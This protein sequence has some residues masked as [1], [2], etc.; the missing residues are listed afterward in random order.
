MDIR[1]RLALAL[2]SSG[3]S[4]DEGDD[5]LVPIT[6]KLTLLH[7]TG[8]YSRLLS[9]LFGA[10]DKANIQS[11]ILEASFAFQFE[12][13]GRPL[14]YEVRRRSDSDT[15]ID[16]HWEVSPSRNLYMEMRLVQQRQAFTDLFEMQLSRSSYF[17][18]T[19]GGVEDQRETL[20]LQR[21]IFS[22]VL[23]KDGGLIKFSTGTPG[24]YNF[25]VVEV[26]DLHLG[27]TD[28]YD[29]LLATYGDPAVPEVARRQ[30]FGLFQKARAKY[31]DFIQ[32]I[33]AKFEL[34]RETVHGVLFLWKR[35]HGNPINFSLE[36]FLIPNQNL[37][38]S[39]EALEIAEDLKGA[40]RPW[41]PKRITSNKVLR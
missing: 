24:D 22:K 5:R 39:Q 14:D 26:S 41:S 25:V 1:R 36:F 9:S 34:F 7:Y 30:L 37:M 6:E 40:M 21:L 17:G 10:N 15:S 28:L 16:F 23:N 32:E 13:S 8:R 3:Y 27:M 19:L 29:C 31:P 2:S 33:A 11:L 4:I 38:T 35:P 20:R 18:T 12:A